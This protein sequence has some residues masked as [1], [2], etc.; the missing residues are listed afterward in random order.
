VCVC[1]C[2]LL[3]LLLHPCKDICNNLYSARDQRWLSLDKLRRRQQD[4]HHTRAPSP[5]PRS[6]PP[7][8][9]APTP[10]QAPPTNEHERAGTNSTPAS[11]IP[12]ITYPTHS[13]QPTNQP[14]TP[15]TEWI[16][17]Q[18]DE[19]LGTHNG[20]VKGVEY[21]RC[22]PNCGLFVRPSNV[23]VIEA[24]AGDTMAAARGVISTPQSSRRSSGSMRSSG[25]VITEQ[26]PARSSKTSKTPGSSS[27][28]STA[29]FGLGSKV[30]LDSF[31]FV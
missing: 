19:P 17:I 24:G 13:H 5:T 30:C 12:A 21:F 28:S 18:L 15:G 9:T 22:K 26:S 14:T 27:R 16:G 29:G 20:T 25:G 2:V 11:P 3:L 6:A 1:V 23:T 10:T 31:C 8:H 7:P 4:L